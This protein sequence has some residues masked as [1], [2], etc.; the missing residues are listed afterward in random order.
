[1]PMTV[2]GYKVGREEASQG[3]CPHRVYGL[4]RKPELIQVNT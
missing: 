4:A 1:M 2:L 3:P